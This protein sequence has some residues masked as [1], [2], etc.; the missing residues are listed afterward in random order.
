[1]VDPTRP[2]PTPEPPTPEPPPFEAPVPAAPRP[3]SLTRDDEDSPGVL[4]G[5]GLDLKRHRLTRDPEFPNARIALAHDWLVGLRG[6]EKVLDSIARLVEAR[7]TPGP[8]YTM[9]ASKKSIT[10]AIDRL[11]VRTSGLNKYPASMRRWLLPR[12]PAAVASLSNRFDADHNAHPINLLVSTSSAAIKALATAESVPHLCYCH[13]PARYL[14]DQEHE[15]AKGSPLRKIGLSMFGDKL[16][17]WDQKSVRAVTNFI[18]NS[19]FTASRIEA[20]WSRDAIVIYPPID[21]GFFCPDPDEPRGEFWL[22][23]SALVPYKRT[24]LAIEAAMRLGKPLMIVGTGSEE[25]SLRR[26]VK[27]TA[28]NLTKMGFSPGRDNLVEFLGHVEQSQLRTLYRR[29]A[30]LVFPQ[31]EDFGIAAAEA[32][33]CGCPVITRRQSGAAEIVLEGRTGAFIDE[34]TA[35][36]IIQAAKAI[37]DQCHENCRVNAERFSE[38]RF[39]AQMGEQ[40]RKQLSASA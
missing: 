2:T 27:K 36:A 20:C 18:A 4:R 29:A 6:G 11:G 21:T 23:V 37:P 5:E 1:M 14:W 26:L 28:R 16:R 25:R 32:Q 8:L 31:V 19:K 9:F 35:D 24:D 38:E 22:T 7:H 10:P 40:I 39:M 34:A 33:A 3:S 13:T 12:Y 17:A 15:Y 30:L